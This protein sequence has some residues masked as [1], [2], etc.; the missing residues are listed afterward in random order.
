MLRLTSA[1]LLLRGLIKAQSADP[2]FDTHHLFLVRANF[3]DDRAKAVS[4][5]RLLDDALKA[6][7]EIDSVASGM[8][9]MLNTWTPPIIVKDA[10]AL[11]GELHDR[12]LASYASD[13]YFATLGITLISG[14]GFTPLEAAIGAHV[15]I[16]SQSTARHF[17]PGEDPLGKHFQLDEKFDGKLSDYEVIGVT[18]DVRFSNLTRIDPMHIYLATNAADLNPTLNQC[19]S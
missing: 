7:P 11:Q 8:C 1:G 16:I 4:R 19:Q 10:G 15:S 14:R 6:V 12:T 9:P 17:W 2:G 18:G 5:S 3:G 13:T